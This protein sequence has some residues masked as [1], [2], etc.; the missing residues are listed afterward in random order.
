MWITNLLLLIVIFTLMIH[1]YL[2]IVDFL[3]HQICKI[4]IKNLKN[5]KEIYT[6][7]RTGYLGEKTPEQYTHIL[8]VGLNKLCTG[9]CKSWIFLIQKLYT[10]SAD[11]LSADSYLELLKKSVLN[12]FGLFKIQHSCSN[13]RKLCG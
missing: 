6:C 5:Q 10:L 8:H 4:Y 11:S 12:G 9:K 3:R 2:I 7:I 13:P 1:F